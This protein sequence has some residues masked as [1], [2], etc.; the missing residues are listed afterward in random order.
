[1]FDDAGRILRELFHLLLPSRSTALR[2]ATSCG[3]IMM[4]GR[5]PSTDGASWGCPDGRGFRRPSRGGSPRGC[6]ILPRGVVR[7]RLT[8]RRARRRPDRCREEPP[9]PGAA[10]LRRIGPYAPLTTV[11]SY[12]AYAMVCSGWEPER[13]AARCCRT[14]EASRSI[15]GGGHTLRS[16]LRTRRSR[17]G[18]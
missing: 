2:V 17:D 18:R 5:L 11:R 12:R 10:G 3:V 15:T 16:W 6:L 7:F 14:S 8:A 9:R 13:R 4:P 1:L